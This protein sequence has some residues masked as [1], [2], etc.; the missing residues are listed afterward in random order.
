M[1]SCA[2]AGNKLADRQDGQIQSR[3][4]LQNPKDG[5]TNAQD[6]VMPPL[7]GCLSAKETGNAKTAAFLP[8]F[9]KILIFK[10]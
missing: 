2:S 7:F 3:A 9:A 1:Q 10:I 5:S 6:C 8:I 4:V